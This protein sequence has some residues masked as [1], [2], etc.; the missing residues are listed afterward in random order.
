M[1]ENDQRLH[2]AHQQLG[3]GPSGSASHEVPVSRQV[4]IDCQFSQLPAADFP[5]FR[6]I[7]VHVLV[8]RIHV[9]IA[10]YEAGFLAFQNHVLYF[11]TCDSLD[12]W[13][14]GFDYRFL[15]ACIQ[16]A[17]SIGENGIL[18]PKLLPTIVPTSHTVV[19]A[20]Y[21]VLR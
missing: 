10:D 9:G 2:S 6:H 12:E 5:Y 21:D 3:A 15:A 14:E 19:E 4:K 7:L 13:S 17:R 8:F 1:G 16:N 20:I 18:R 11:Q